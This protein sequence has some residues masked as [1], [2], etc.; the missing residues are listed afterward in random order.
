LHL[1]AIGE[2]ETELV[3]VYRRSFENERVDQQTFR[4]YVV[5]D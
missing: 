2:G 3:L 1:E 4:V 5:V